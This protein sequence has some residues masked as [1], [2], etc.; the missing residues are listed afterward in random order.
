MP[1]IN[2]KAL[3]EACFDADVDYEETVREDYSGRGMYG[4]TCFGLVTP[5]QADAFKILWYYNAPDE[6]D[7]SKV[8]E[9]LDDMRTDNMGYDVIVY[10]PGWTLTEAC[11][12]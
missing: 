1:T 3:E 9:L 2:R 5:S 7:F 8:P 6:R 11:D 4:A 12:D 10:F